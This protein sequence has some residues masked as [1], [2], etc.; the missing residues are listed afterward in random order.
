[1][2]A[3]TATADV[4]Y[5]SYAACIS[6]CAA[7]PSTG[8]VTPLDTSGDTVQCRN[9]HALAA[10]T[11][12]DTT[13]H[14]PHAGPTGGG[15]C[16]TICDGY[17]DVIQLACGTSGTDMQFADTASCLTAC[18]AYAITGTFG[19]STG[20]TIQCRMYHATVA[21]AGDASVKTTHCPHA[22]QTSITTYCGATTTTGSSSVTSMT[23]TTSTTSMTGTA[24]GANVLQ[25]SFALIATMAA[26]LLIAKKL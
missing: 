26:A 14:C 5:S 16:G 22:G 6:V 2:A 21:L 24:S 20:N 3:C 18:A 17:C 7:F 10:V 9:Y 15:Q 1:M 19:D 12:A 13:N 25:A 8:T 11:L 4:Q 23:S